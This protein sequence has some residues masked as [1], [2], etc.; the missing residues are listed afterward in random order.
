MITQVELNVDGVVVRG[1][2]FAAEGVGPG[3]GLVMAPGFSATSHFAV[4]E[5]Y[6][7]GIADAGVSVLLF[8]VR[9][10]GYSDGEPRHEINPWAQARDY[11]AAIAFLRSTDGIDP[12]RVGIWGVSLS[13]AIASVV[14]AADPEIAAV[15]LQVPAFGDEASPP[16]PTGERFDAIRDTLLHADFDTMSRVS[17]GPLPVVSATQEDVPALLQPLTSFR[18]FI[19]SGARFGTEW[20]NRATVVRLD[21]PVPFDSQACVPHIAAPTLMLIAEHDEMEGADADVARGVF[22]LASEPKHLVTVQGGHFGVLYDGSPEFD[23]S[24]AAQR[25]FLTAHLLR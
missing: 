4:F 10:F 18:W 11:R 6:A 21:T 2:L 24:L 17:E 20:A 5:S 8:D 22:A 16:D 12:S 13:A 9:G 23:V 19:D 1:R 25:R 15:V 7:R 3:P 14:A